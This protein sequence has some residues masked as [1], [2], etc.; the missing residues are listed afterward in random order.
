VTAEKA[1][2]EKGMNLSANDVERKAV[3]LT[4]NQLVFVQCKVHAC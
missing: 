2:L 3:H 1:L 4:C